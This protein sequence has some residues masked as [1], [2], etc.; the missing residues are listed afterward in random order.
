[1]EQAPAWR[2]LRFEIASSALFDRMAACGART[3]I[4]TADTG[5]A[6]RMAAF[7]VQGFPI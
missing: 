2:E 5:L 3:Q 7:E 6:K 4:S 1:M